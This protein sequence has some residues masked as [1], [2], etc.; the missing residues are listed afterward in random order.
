LI[1]PDVY[2][3]KTVLIRKSVT[4]A[5]LTTKTIKIPYIKIDT[6]VKNLVVVNGA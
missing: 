3:I 5:I 2:I 4:D 6:F 1:P